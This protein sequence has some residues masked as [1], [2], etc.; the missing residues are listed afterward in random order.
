MRIGA[1]GRGACA[2]GCR[3]RG[4]GRRGGGRRVLARRS[5]GRPV[6]VGRHH[7]SI[8]RTAPT[9]RPSTP[10][11][12]RLVRDPVAARGARD[13][14]RGRRR[15][16]DRDRQERPLHPAGPGLPAR[17]AAPGGAGR[18]RDHARDADD[19]L[20]AQPLLADVL[21]VELRA[22]GRSRTSS[23]CA[24]STTWRSAW[25]TAVEEACD[26]LVPVRVGA[27]VGTVR[28]DA[29]PLVRPGD[30]RRRHAGGLSEVGHRPRPDGDPLRRRQRPGESEAAREPRQLSAAT[31][32]SSRATT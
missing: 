26:D 17:R 25:S 6:R 29:S 3:G 7:S 21:V 23:T 4:A 11:G 5:V 30:R 24:S 18:L 22:S 27:A 31:R 2:C 8:R 1:R 12:A 9:T 20:D 28:Q 10:T 32:S 15:R 14:R 13:R 19:G 16:T